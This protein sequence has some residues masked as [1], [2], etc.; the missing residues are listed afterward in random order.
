M[1]SARTL[2][3]LLEYRL[4]TATME[5]Y[6]ELSGK[7]REA[8][9]VDVNNRPIISAETSPESQGGDPCAS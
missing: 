9:G 4:L 8:L 2:L 1:S 7:V 3:A 5:E 6:I